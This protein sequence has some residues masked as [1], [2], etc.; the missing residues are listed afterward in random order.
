MKGGRQMCSAESIK[1]M[2]MMDHIQE[3]PRTDRRT[4]RNQRHAWLTSDGVPRGQIRVRLCS[5][6]PHTAISKAGGERY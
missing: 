5:V 3:H 4:R 2:Q 1:R 6:S